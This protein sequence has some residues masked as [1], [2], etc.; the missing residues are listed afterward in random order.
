MLLRKNLIYSALIIIVFIVGLAVGN[1]LSVAQYEEKIESLES[2]LTEREKQIEELNASINDLQR[3]L[4]NNITAYEKKIAIYESEIAFLQNRIVNLEAQLEIKI[5][6]I[7]FSPKGGCEDAIL[8]WIR[9]ANKSIHVLIYSFTLDSIS[10]ELI[11][12]YKRG[13]DVKVVFERN[14]INRWSE[15]WRLR[16]E[17]VPVRNDTNPKLMHNKVMII[18]GEIVFTGSYNWSMNAEKYNNENLIIIRSR[19]I[20]EIFERKFEEIWSESVG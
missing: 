13:V 7:Y 14:Q 16:E 1:Y 5:I 10:E 8:K 2:E 6:G 3:W 15:Y 18:D 11:N 9:S 4:E 20:A 17:G 19:K 12:A